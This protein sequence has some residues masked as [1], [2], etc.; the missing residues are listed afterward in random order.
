MQCHLITPPPL[1]GKLTAP[2]SEA[3]ETAGKSI[4]GIL[5]QSILLILDY[6]PLQNDWSDKFFTL[7]HE[8]KDYAKYTVGSNV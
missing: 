3:S 1:W 5:L 6:V 8:N 2:P 4:Q 7:R